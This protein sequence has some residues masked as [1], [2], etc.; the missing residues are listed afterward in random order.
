MIYGE[1]GVLAD[2]GEKVQCHICGKWFFALSTHL[3]RRHKMGAEDYKALYGLNRG[4]SLISEAY[5]RQLRDIHSDRMGQY[6]GLY[7]LRENIA[8]TGAN[9][10]VPMRAQGKK[11]LSASISKKYQS[12]TV[13]QQMSATRKG[14][15]KSDSHKAK[16]SAGLK[17]AY[18]K[19]DLKEARRTE[20]K[21]RHTEKPLP[22]IAGKWSYLDKNQNT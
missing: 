22:R 2:D 6:A 12:G 8:R 1:I 10:A 16:I 3:S 15:P 9:P 19:S 7:D 4:T 18:A 11:Q 21:K 5:K 17:E 20:S 13:Q 14:V